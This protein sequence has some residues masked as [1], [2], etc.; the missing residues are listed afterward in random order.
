MGPHVRQ[1]S[2]SASL[3]THALLFFAAVGVAGNVSTW[4]SLP[5]VA[6]ISSTGH[7]GHHATD[8]HD[9][10]RRAGL[11]AKREEEEGGWPQVRPG[12]GVEPPHPCLGAW[13]VLHASTWFNNARLVLPRAS[14]S[15]RRTAIIMRFFIIAG[16]FFSLCGF[17]EQRL[18]SSNTSGHIMSF[19]AKICGISVCCHPPKTR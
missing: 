12:V 18:S 1:R 7:G 17:Y 19:M 8:T 4:H 15:L 3:C 16:S 5:F 13:R 11:V 14:A 10:K 6:G 2:E 9:G